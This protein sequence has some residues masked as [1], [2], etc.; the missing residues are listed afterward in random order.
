MR[1]KVLEYCEHKDI[2][3]WDLPSLEE[4]LKL[5]LN[6]SVNITSKEF[7][8]KLHEAEDPQLFLFQYIINECKKYYE[9]KISQIGESDFSYIEKRIVLDIIDAKWKEHLYH[10]DQLREGIWTSSY[11]EKNPLVEYKLKGF[12]LFDEMMDTIKEHVVEFLF[13]IQIEGPVQVEQEQKDVR[14]IGTEKHESINALTP[15][16]TNQKAGQPVVVSGGGA[17]KRKSLRRR[18]RR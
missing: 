13:R 14:K 15:G 10:M 6:V 3:A 18:K 5:S 11:S 8:E 7:L 12:E 4:W 16:S 9:N 2:D 17:S 1:K